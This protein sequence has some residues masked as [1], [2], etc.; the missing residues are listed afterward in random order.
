[1]KISRKLVAGGLVS[2]SEFAVK[3]VLS[4]FAHK[5]SAL[6]HSTRLLGGY[7]AARLVD[8]CVALLEQE[9]ALNDRTC[10]MLKQILSILSLDEGAEL[11]KHYMGF[12]A[13][14]DPFDPVLE[15]IRLLRDELSFAIDEAEKR[16]SWME[17]QK[18]A[19]V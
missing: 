8:R 11:N 7:E 3:P 1:M 15:E 19:S 9:H 10:L 2:P 17:T 6:W 18:D 13:V 14:I 5:H 12:F 16:L 4:L